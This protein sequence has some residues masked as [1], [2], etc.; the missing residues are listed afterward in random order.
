MRLSIEGVYK[1]ACVTPQHAPLKKVLAETA[2]ILPAGMKDE[3]RRKRYRS[4]SSMLIVTVSFLSFINPAFCQQGQCDAPTRTSHRQVYRVGVLA[5]RGLNAAFEEFNTTFHDYLTATAGARFDPP[6]RF[7]MNLLDILLTNV[8]EFDFIYTNPFIFSCAESEIGAQ[9]LVSQVTRHEIQTT[10]I[11]DST[12]YGL[13]KYGGVI[14]TRANSSFETINEIRGE[15][16]ACTSIWG[17]GSG[18]MQFRVLHEAGL[19]SIN[20]PRQTVFT[21]NEEE[22]V[23]GVLRGDFDVGFVR[24]GMLERMNATEI[25]IIEP[26][27]D[28]S[29]DGVVFPSQSSTQLYPEWNVAA[30]TH[31]PSAV[32]LEVT[33]AMLAI[34]DHAA[35]GF[36]IFACYAE[37]GCE[38]S[39]KQG[40]KCKKE[41]ETAAPLKR[42]D[43]TVNL[44]LTAH[45]AMTR[46]RFAGFRPSLSY[47]ELRNLQAETQFIEKNQDTGIRHCV[48]SFTCPDG[49]YKRS[50]E[51]IENGCALASLTCGEG[52]QCLCSP[53]EKRFGVDAFPLGSAESCCPKLAVCGATE[54]RK[55]LIFHAVDNKRR[56]GLDLIVKIFDGI[57]SR[58]IQAHLVDRRGNESSL[59]NATYEFTVE[60]N[61]VGVL[62]LEIFADGEYTEESP[63]RVEI[64]GRDCATDLLEANFEGQC[65]CNANF[66]D[67]G[68]KCVSYDYLLSA[69]LLPV[70]TL[71]VIGVFMYIKYVQKQAD[72]IWSV[73]LSDLVFDDPAEII[74]RGTFGLVLLA[75]YRGTQVAVKRVIPPCARKEHR[76]KRKSKSVDEDSHS[77]D[78]SLAAEPEAADLQKFK[79]E[80]SE[81]ASSGSVSIPD[82]ADFVDEKGSNGHLDLSARSQDDLPVI[83]THNKMQRSR[84]MGHYSTSGPVVA[85]SSGMEAMR[86]PRRHSL[87]CAIGGSR[88]LAV[89]NT[90]V[91]KEPN[92]K[93]KRRKSVEGAMRTAFDIEDEDDPVCDITYV[94][95]AD[96][97]SVGSACWTELTSIFT[98]RKS[99]NWWS[100]RRE[101]SRLKADFVI[102]MRHL[103]KLRHPCITT[104][105]GAVVCLKEEP[106]LVMEYMDNGSLQD[107]LH[108]ETM[109]LEGELVLPILRDITCGVRFLHSACPPIIHGDLKAQNVL[110]DSKFRAKVSDFGLTLKKGVGA[111]GTP[112]WMAPELLRGESDN[113]AA[114]D[115]YSFGIILYEVY[116][117]KDPY[118]GEDMKAVIEQVADP[119]VNKRPPVPPAC[120]PVVASLMSDC[121]SADPAERPTFERLDLRLKSLDVWNVEPGK[122]RFSRQS[123][124]VLPNTD[125]LDEVFPEHV[126]TALR[127]GRKIEP[128]SRDCVTIFFSDIVGFTTIASI[129]SPMKVSD[130]LDRLYLI[131]DMLSLNHDVFKVETIGDAYM[132]A[133][134]L[135]K[136]Q[137][138]HVKRIAEF[139]IDTVRAANETMI[140]V[141][142]PSKGFVKIRVGFHSG[143]V[144]ANVVGSRSPR[145]SLFGDSVNTAARMESTS[146]KNRIQCSDRSASMLMMNHPE[147]RLASRGLIKVKG[148]GEIHTFWVNEDES[149]NFSSGF[150]TFR[151]SR[152]TSSKSFSNIFSSVQ[153]LKEASTKSYSS[154]LSTLHNQKDESS[155]K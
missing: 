90:N 102:E 152:D 13:T 97:R 94:S 135:V 147:I 39:D 109:I 110:V 139:A 26:R 80:G 71:F 86:M 83:N 118:T 114:S 140:D 142:D 58:E 38:G 154:S 82:L 10:G 141:D 123:K 49:Y 30:L 6:I 134:N 143:P 101:Y 137:D 27:N 63:L 21:F 100:R 76:S 77:P 150:S 55:Q 56:A 107:I 89:F 96:T 104:V 127:Q 126:A 53:C 145:Y 81:D 79:N 2:E 129:L 29:T 131:F 78:A 146:Q 133:T 8:Q 69:I 128:E 124:K 65:V 91:D 5:T 72:S 119:I 12:Q 24:T 111:T 99:D 32:A 116:S 87:D 44:A 50:E 16:V 122:V 62:L 112:F 130:M 67:F 59:S 84:S 15:I 11:F 66:V 153:Q 136:D 120:P 105:M 28:L 68:G 37:F 74:G 117:R 113:T 23:K 40:D 31:V 42:C 7:E 73:K 20:D 70:L 64:L 35:M 92:G 115:V 9:S 46:G 155:L 148:K 85:G 17:L 93:T 33:Q 14:F 22:V 125:L 60:S 51:E 41:C 103:S 138:D 36:N 75:E 47:M 19:S 54:Q 18:Q 132:A 149:Q 3:S 121:L 61:H 144:V 106:M 151:L 48:R 88:P 45:K 43:T 95:L 1:N 52:F 4:M 25:K 108:N 98:A 34:G 57:D